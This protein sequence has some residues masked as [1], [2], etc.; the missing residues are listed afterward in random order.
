MFV[1]K[2]GRVVLSAVKQPAKSEWQSEPA[3][4]CQQA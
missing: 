2:G 1:I 3:W 4:T